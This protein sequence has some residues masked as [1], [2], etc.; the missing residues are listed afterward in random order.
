M[1]NIAGIITN[2]TILE[3]ADDDLGRVLGVNFFGTFYGAQ[4]AARAMVAQGRG[5]I[6]NMLSGAVDTPAPT[7][8]AYAISKSAGRQLTMTLAVELASAGVRVNAVAPGLVVTGITARH[9]TAADGTVDEEAKQAYLGGIREHTPL[10]ILGESDDI[11]YSVLYLA[12]DASRFMTGQ[13]LRPNG[14]AAMPG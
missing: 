9:Y 11:A 14:G 5:S 10:G 8:G 7:I 12:S 3:L 2:S 4:A 1:C 6:I 13:V